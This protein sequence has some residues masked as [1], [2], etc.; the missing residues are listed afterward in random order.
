MKFFCL[1]FVILSCYVQASHRKIHS[2]L[3]IKEEK[4]ALLEAEKLFDKEPSK[5]HFQDY[6]LCLATIG[7]EKRWQKEWLHFL[8]LYPEDAYASSLLEPMAWGILERGQHSSSPQIRQITLVASVLTRDAR[9]I[10]LLLSALKDPL[11]EIRSVAVEL[12]TLYRDA[13]LKHELKK[14]GEWE[15]IQMVR[16]EILRAFGALHM[17][18]MKPMILQAIETQQLSTEETIA[19][20]EA[21]VAMTDSLSFSDL[22]HLSKSKKKVLRMIAVEALIKCEK[23]EDTQILAALLHDASYEVVALALRALGLLG[24]EE[25]EG[26]SV[27]V[28]A[29]EHLDSKHALLAICAAWLLQLHQNDVAEKTFLYWIENGTDDEKTLASAVLANLGGH[30]IECSLACLAKTEHPFVI[31]NLCSGLIG[32]RKDPELVCK[33]IAEVLE[34]SERWME[35]SVMGFAVLRKSNLAHK[36]TI[37]HYPELVSQALKMQFVSF[38]VLLEYPGAI[39]NLKKF[40]GEKWQLTGLTAELLLQEGEQE[41]L[42][43]IQILLDDKDQKVALEAAIILAMWG[44]DPRALPYLMQ[45]YPLMS[46][47]E[48]MRILEALSRIKDPTILPFF[49]ECLG[50]SSELLRC[51]VACCL[52]QTLNH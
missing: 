34:R 8:K 48:K 14:M 38:L 2:Y 4:K 41:A 39:E 52:I 49:V 43:S 1:A 30:A 5:E 24:I 18:S 21:L 19:A 11:A 17:E 50:E 44:R 32:Q 40:L 9:A 7:E 51:V 25:I 22:Q 12:A 13:P 29:K 37:P 16:A 23:K 27:E 31:L 35:E 20:V 46:L 3:L 10:P 36:K 6:L 47:Q 26:K 28:I 42:E 45:H 33:K 15:R